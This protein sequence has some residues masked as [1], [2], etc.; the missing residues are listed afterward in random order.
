[1]YLV[2]LYRNVCKIA[3]LKCI[4]DFEWKMRQANEWQ[5]HHGNNSQQCHGWNGFRTSLAC[6][7]KSSN[8]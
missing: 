3:I 8:E 2:N 4:Y 6:F 1:M 7:L 5:K